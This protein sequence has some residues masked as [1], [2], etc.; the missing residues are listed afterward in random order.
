MATTIRRN[1]NKILNCVKKGKLSGE[2]L[3][4]L[5][6][7]SEYCSVRYAAGHALGIP[8]EELDKHTSSFEDKLYSELSLPLYNKLTM[9][10][11]KKFDKS[12]IEKNL[13]RVDRASSDLDA[14]YLLKGDEESR[15]S[16]AKT[17]R[18][19]EQKLIDSV[20]NLNLVLDRKSLERIY[21]KKMRFGVKPPYKAVDRAGFQLGYG[22]LRI[23][24]EKKPLETAVQS[25]FW[26]G[27]AS[28]TIYGTYK[29]DQYLQTIELPQ[30]HNSS[31]KR[32]DDIKFWHTH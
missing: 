32:V 14:L 26:V 3:Q 7:S 27:V 24:L 9:G 28:L 25:L 23:M 18:D 22:S 16:L 2:G 12:Q 6:D 11:S 8:N 15:T 31:I 5:Y 1:L 21:R 4:K 30:R 10:G 17:L 20:L 13:E 29:M 19:S